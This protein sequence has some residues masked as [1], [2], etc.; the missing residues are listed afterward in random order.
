MLAT[1]TGTTTIAMNPD[2]IAIYRSIIGT[3]YETL[4]STVASVEALLATPMPPEGSTLDDHID[5]VTWADVAEGFFWAFL[6]T[7]AGVS[8]DVI[9]AMVISAVAEIAGDAA[10]EFPYFG[11]ILGPSVECSIKRSHNIPC[12]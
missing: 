11:W 10:S 3:S 4:P 7:V 5:R 6:S 12:D 8:I 1:S 2:D 9:E